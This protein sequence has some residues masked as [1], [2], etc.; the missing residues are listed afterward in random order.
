MAMRFLYFQNSIS[1]SS[2]TIYAYLGEFHNDRNRSRAIMCASVIFGLFCILLPGIAWLVI[3]QSWQFYLPI[4]EIWFK[5]WKLFL[6]VCGTPSLLCA[7][8]FF[9][10]PESPK[11]VL[12]QG[13]QERTVEILEKINRWNNGGRQAQPLQIAEIYEE[14]ESIE[15]RRKMLANSK[16]SFSLLKSMWAQT[17]PL[18]MAPHL[19]T[20]FL[21]CFLQ[22][23]IFVTSN[24]MYMWFP[25]ILN[26]MATN[27]HENPGEKISLCNIV[28]M[29]RPNV[30]AIASNAMNASDMHCVTKLEISTYEHSMVL[31]MLYVIGFAF[32]GAII[33]AV[34]KLVILC[35]CW[36]S[37]TFVHR[38]NLCVQGIF[39]SMQTCHLFK[40]AG[41]IL[42]LCGIAGIIT[43][44]VDIPIVA[45]YFYVILLCCGLG[46][47]IV[48]AAT[49]ELYPT[50]LRYLSNP[51]TEHL[52][53]L[54]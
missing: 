53:K 6:L 15:N 35:E 1:G 18:F 51:L 4:A 32:I 23:G 10:L 21:A 24:G 3:N 50:N 30:S 20:T 54:A 25:D 46:V 43:V 33:N 49:V 11:F 29:T 39:F 19:K 16:R 26:R 48:N 7:V 47:T 44:L 31:E 38:T 28:Y 45:I 12:G 52:H 2:A 36:I 22:F 17:A 41:G 9:F 37:R 5:P 8:A 40:F 42:V 13:N 14:M 34:G 27:V